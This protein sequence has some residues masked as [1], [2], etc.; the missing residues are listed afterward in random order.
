[1]KCRHWGC[2]ASVM[3]PPT[4]EMCRKLASPGWRWPGDDKFPSVGITLCPKHA[5]EDPRIARG[6]RR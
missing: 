3:G 1:M 5:P 4:L 6:A 2:L